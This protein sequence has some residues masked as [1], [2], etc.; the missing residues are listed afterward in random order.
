MY[1]NL[2]HKSLMCLTLAK[3]WDILSIQAKLSK[4]CLNQKA[5][6]N[7]KK[8]K[9]K[10]VKFTAFIFFN[11]IPFYQ[12]NGRK[13]KNNGSCDCFFKYFY[14]ALRI[15]N[16]RK[17]FYFFHFNLYFYFSRLS[18]WLIYTKQ[19]S[20]LKIKRLETDRM[21]SLLSSLIY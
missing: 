12:P 19:H 2:L 9:N 1:A 18:V 7:N 5:L 21:V 20:P 13:V 14:I 4:I 6:Q 15:I 8:L 3:V 16:A 17:L 10:A 11:T